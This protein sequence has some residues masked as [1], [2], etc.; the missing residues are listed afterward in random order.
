MK[1][2]IKKIGIAVVAI[3]VIVSAFIFLLERPES[4]V[5][6]STSNAIK[7]MSVST[8][9]TCGVASA[10][11]LV[12]SSGRVY[13]AFVNDSANPVYLSMNGAAAVAN[14]GLRLN[15]GGGSYEIN[16]FNQYIGQVNCIAPAGA[17]IVTVSASQ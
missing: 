9:V 2:A 13:A 17:S 1:N 5:A 8:G 4:V 12:A 16:Q 15:A 11:L 6:Q 3:A 14:A 10:P 7:T